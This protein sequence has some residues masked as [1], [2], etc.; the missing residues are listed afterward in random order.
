M[1]KYLLCVKNGITTL[2][3]AFGGYKRGTV[4]IIFNPVESECSIIKKI[5]KLKYQITNK[6]QIP[7]PN[8]Q[9]VQS[10]ETHRFAMRRQPD[11]IQEDSP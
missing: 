8:D 7:V 5:P 4:N 10:I 2:S 11:M 9:S 3:C 1:T 6:F